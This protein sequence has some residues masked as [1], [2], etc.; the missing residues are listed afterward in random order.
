MDLFV[1][2]LTALTKV[3]GGNLGL[4]IIFIGIVSRVIFYPFL[5]SSI[6]QAKVLREIKPK[7][8]AIKKKFPNDRNR[9]A[10]EQARIYREAGFNPAAS[11]ISPLV[12]LAVAILLFNALTRLIHTDIETSFLWWDL[13][14]PDA[15]PINNFPLKIP[16][17]LVVLTAVATFLQSKMMLPPP[18]VTEKND[19]KAEL[20]YLLPVIILWSGTQFPAGLALFWLV[21]TLVGIYQQYTISGLGGLAS[22][23]RIWKR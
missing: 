6:N 17:I 13:A 23:Q 3:F 8:D 15:Y 1:N 4:T 9:V 20:V 18:V 12:Q 11:C 16:G 21:S 22:W 19:R 2:L 14:S 7:L 10:Q 5:K